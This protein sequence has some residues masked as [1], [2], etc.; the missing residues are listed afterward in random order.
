[1]FP[2][3]KTIDDV[4]PA[5]EGRD[6]FIV[7]DKGDYVVVNYN[8]GFE[9]T[10]DID[11]EN[12][13]LGQLRRE[14]R[15]IIFYPD[16]RIMSRPFH[17]F[18]NIGEREETL[19]R[20]IDMTRDHFVMEKMDG[21]MIRPLFVD[22]EVRLGT[23]MGITDTSLAAE[24]ITTH[25]ELKWMKEAMAV[26]LTPLFEFISP[27]NRIVLEYNRSELVLLAVRRNITGD[28][29]SFDQ[30]G[31]TPFEIVPR[32]G[33]VEGTLEDY[34]ARQRGLE[35]REGDIISFGN[36]MHKLKNDWYVRIH[37]VKDKIRTDRHILALLLE[38]ELDDV[39]P[40]LDENDYNRVKKYERDFHNA[41]QKT[42]EDLNVRAIFAIERAKGDR[43]QLATKI[44]PESGM[45]KKLWG[46]IFGAA[47]GKDMND[48][49]MRR[50]RSGLGNTAKYNELAH[51]L[52]LD[53]DKGEDNV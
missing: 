52:G 47:D 29:L 5:V 16:G 25:H 14:C 4:L 44:L 7:A 36:E 18:F 48:L 1:M 43:K 40:H 51:F 32:Y 3:I 2:T 53:D 6:E 49:L 12:P 42:L 50:V 17:K 41:F 22:D 8:V 30:I 15:G 37:K 35:G 27:D 26:G 28:Y 10:F 23:K 38:N 21:S 33:S 11:P 13:L 24:E 39:Y 46:F 45:D 19:T 20:N 34:I 31:Q 9:D